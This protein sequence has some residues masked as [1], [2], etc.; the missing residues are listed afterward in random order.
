MAEARSLVSELPA[1]EGGYMTEEEF[2][3]QLRNEGFAEMVTVERES[4]GRLAA[5]AHPFESKALILS[6]EIG[7]IVDGRESCYRTGDVFHLASGQVHEEWYG[8]L[9]VRYLVG[10]R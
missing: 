4:N 1:D 5:H 8:P 10:R 7:L 3:R 2:S 9:G 6:G